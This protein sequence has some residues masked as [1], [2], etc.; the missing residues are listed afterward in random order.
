M[1]KQ[2]M[3][4]IEDDPVLRDAYTTF[5]SH[6]GYEVRGAKDEK[7]GIKLANEHKPDIVLLD[8]LLPK[9]T[10]FDFL[11]G[12]D[13]KNT[14]TKVFVVT[15]LLSPETTGAAEDLGAYKVLHKSF[16]TPT[17]LSEAINEAIR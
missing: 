9:P 6:K 15:N 11:R 10:G 14:S 3:L 13:V 16:Y 7:E 2:V 1:T 8:L 5:F 12:Y 17:E 4:V